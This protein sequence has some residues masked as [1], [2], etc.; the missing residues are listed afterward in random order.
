MIF[1]N[2]EI[3]ELEN[4]GCNCT[5]FMGYKDN[6]YFSLDKKKGLIIDQYIYK[7]DKFVGINTLEGATFEELINKLK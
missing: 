5:P 6:L 7:K 1:N 3:T 4:I 2:I